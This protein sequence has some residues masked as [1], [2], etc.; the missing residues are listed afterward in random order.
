M[1]RYQ[2]NSGIGKPY[3]HC[4]VV[5]RNTANEY[6]EGAYTFRHGIVTFYSEPTFVTFS[7]VFGCRMH[8]LSLSDI[9]KP[10][11]ERQLIV[12]AGK[13]GREVVSNFK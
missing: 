1:K 8:W 10:L 11:T 12:Q 4:H 13:F 5:N 9:K 6:K 2:K 3:G 7:F